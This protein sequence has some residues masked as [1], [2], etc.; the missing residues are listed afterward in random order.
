M[1]TGI[2]VVDELFQFLTGFE[3]RHAL[4]WNTYRI[5]GLGIS[6]ASRAALADTETAKAAQFDLLALIKCFNN[7]FEYNFDQT[8]CVFFSKL[9]RPRYVFNEFCFR[10]ASPRCL[11]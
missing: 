4:R 11:K 9:S 3:I 7:A 2:I 10:H 5:A 1:R 6:A 8:L